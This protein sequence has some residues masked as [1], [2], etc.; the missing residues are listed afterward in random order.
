MFQGQLLIPRLLLNLYTSIRLGQDNL[1]KLITNIL[2]KPSNASHQNISPDDEK[3]RKLVAQ[4]NGGDLNGDGYRSL[5]Y[6]GLSLIC[7]SKLTL[8]NNGLRLIKAMLQYGDRVH[9]QQREQWL[10]D[11][12]FTHNSSGDSANS[13]LSAVDRISQTSTRIADLIR[14]GLVSPVC[15]NSSVRTFFLKTILTGT[16]LAQA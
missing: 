7:C 3:T 11:V 16:M 12:I 4:G 15:C 2:I 8:F 13:G 10:L 14:K 9:K 6:A 1:V 5:I